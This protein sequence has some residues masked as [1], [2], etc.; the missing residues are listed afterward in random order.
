MGGARFDK[1]RTGQEAQKYLP[2][3]RFASVRKGGCKVRISEE[4]GR[5]GNRERDLGRWFECVKEQ[6][7]RK[8]AR[9][10]SW[11]LGERVDHLGHYPKRGTV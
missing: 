4:G 11:R 8:V 7:Q 5:A 1:R 10:S 3:K 6:L 2:I 9:A